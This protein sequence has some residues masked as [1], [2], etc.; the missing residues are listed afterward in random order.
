MMVW[1]LSFFVGEWSAIEKEMGDG[2]QRLV[3]IWM[4]K[5]PENYVELEVTFSVKVLVILLFLKKL[6]GICIVASVYRF[7]LKKLISGMQD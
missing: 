2:L 3:I 6:V 7:D 1:V 4:C 5:Y